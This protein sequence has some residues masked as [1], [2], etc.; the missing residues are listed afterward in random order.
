M[1][2]EPKAVG[3]SRCDVPARA[4]RAERT[5][6][7]VRLRL[8]RRCTRRWTAQRTVPTTFGSCKTVNNDYEKIRRLGAVAA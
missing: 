8:L 2:R 6:Y 5:P 3:T 7:N 1:T 4:E